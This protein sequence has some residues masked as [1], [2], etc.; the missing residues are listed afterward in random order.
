MSTEPPPQRNP[1]VSENLTGKAATGAG[2]SGAAMAARQLLSLGAVAILAR[3]LGPGAYGLMAMASTV[4]V[5]LVNF[6]D[7]GTAA[8]IIQRPTVSQELLST[9][10]WTNLGLGM[11]LSILVI[12]GAGSAAAFFH[13]PQL[14]PVLRVLAGSFVF[15]SAGIVQNAL[16]SRQMKFKLTSLADF[17][18][19]V[20]GYSVSLPMA[21]YG[22]GVWSLVFANL[23]STLILTIMYWILSGWRPTITFR[24]S[25][26][27]EVAGFS[28]NLAGFVLVNYFARNADNMIVGRF[29]GKEPLGYYQLAYT[30]M[31]YPIQNVTSILSDVT[32][33]AF[34]RIQDDNRRFAD[35]YVR[36][37]SLIALIT[38]PLIAGLGVVV[39]PFA[40]AVL[41]S[42]WA[43]VIPIFQILAP[44]G[45]FQSVQSTT[46]S[47]YVAKGRTDWMFR[48]GIVSTVLYVAAFLIGVR[49]GVAGVAGAYAIAYFLMLYPALAIPFRLIDLSV[50]D[51]MRRLWPQFLITGLMA[52]VCMGWLRLL[53]ARGILNAWVQLASTV[54]LGGGVYLFLMLYF[55]PPVVGYLDEALDRS[56]SAPA[57]MARR[58]LHRISRVEGK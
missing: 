39:Q 8:A 56:N 52:A 25:E 6:R 11:A 36:S 1:Q 37:C 53:I 5:F 3:K 10:F 4:I 47:I 14:T 46:G 55:R 15:M 16:L 18:S 40:L 21:I 41:S 17:V 20:A 42:K 57:R 45:M 49:N 38:F 29:L 31:M 33:P 22:Y 58:I 23:V 50:G 24:F 32:L 48:W 35:A 43:A 34:S 7:L 12:L 13:E 26:L 2:W 44:V 27:R 30:L 28:L 19:T 9:L 54:L 51:F